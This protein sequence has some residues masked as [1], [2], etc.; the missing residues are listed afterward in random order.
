MGKFARPKC[1][2]GADLSKR[3]VKLEDT[4]SQLRVPEDPASGEFNLPF[5]DCPK[6][7]HPWPVIGIEAPATEPAEPPAEPPEE[8]PAEPPAEPPEEPPAEPPAETPPAEPTESSS[9][10]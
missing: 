3:K 1:T 6:C 2:C 5:A 4:H 10:D 9:E 7:G 8:P